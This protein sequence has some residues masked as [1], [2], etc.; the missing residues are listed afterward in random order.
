MLTPR[1]SSSSSYLVSSSEGRM[2]PADGLV[3]GKKDVGV[4]TTHHILFPHH[5]IVGPP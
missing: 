3:I 5:E 1:S 2:R 4:F